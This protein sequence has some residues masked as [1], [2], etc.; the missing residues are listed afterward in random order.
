MFT[1]TLPSIFLPVQYLVFISRS[2]FFLTSSYIISCFS[3]YFFLQV[4]FSFLSECLASLFNSGYHCTPGISVLTFQR[5]RVS[6]SFSGFWLLRT[7][8]GAVILPAGVCWWQGAVKGVS[9]DSSLPLL[10]PLVPPSLMQT[11]NQRLQE[12]CFLTA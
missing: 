6:S 2:L 12:V 4:P 1:L 5:G 11:W 9:R 7:Q 10:F 8:L 3:N